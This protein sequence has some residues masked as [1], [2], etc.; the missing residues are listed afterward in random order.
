M[1]V[2]MYECRLEYK[3]HAMFIFS[4]KN[5]HDFLLTYIGEKELTEIPL[6][7]EN[8]RRK[9]REIKTACFDVKLSQGMVFRKFIT[10]SPVESP[11][12][13]EIPAIELIQA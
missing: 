5:K 9:K 1:S 4:E 10:S 11:P 2:S 6:D 3:V 7:N 12:P 13:P 8:R